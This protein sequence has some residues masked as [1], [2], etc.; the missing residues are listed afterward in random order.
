MKI[1]FLLLGLVTQ[2]A[3][4]FELEGGVREMYLTKLS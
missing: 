2:S 1:F 4:A 3:H